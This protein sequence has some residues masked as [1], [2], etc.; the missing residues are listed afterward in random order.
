MSQQLRTTIVRLGTL[1]TAVGLTVGLAGAPASAV[2]IYAEPVRITGP[3]IDL[4]AGS[5][6]WGNPTNSAVL[7]WDETSGRV[8]P[9]I[10]GTLF[11]NNASGTC[12]RVRL[13]AYD[14]N[15]DIVGSRNGGTVCA[16]NGSVHQWSVYF[17]V[18]GDT[19][20]THAHVVLQRQ[21]SSTTYSDEGVSTHDY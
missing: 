2:L 18:A 20:T 10:S 9:I 7:G 12:A 5:L 19:D 21:T 17:D 11:I 1:A 13:E 4:A 16:T 8:S 15:H 6:I 3:E 14:A